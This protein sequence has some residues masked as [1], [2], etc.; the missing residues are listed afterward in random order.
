MDW[1][2]GNIYYKQVLYPPGSIETTGNFEIKENCSN[3]DTRVKHMRGIFKKGKVFEKEILYRKLRHIL[4]KMPSQNYPTL[5][6]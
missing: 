3:L 4:E 2:L 6:I 1:I 5:R